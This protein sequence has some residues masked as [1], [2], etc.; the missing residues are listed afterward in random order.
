MVEFPAGLMDEGETPEMAAVRELKWVHR[1]FCALTKDCFLT[2][3]AHCFTREETGLTGK[4]VSTSGVVFMEPGLTNCSACILNVEVDG[5]RPENVNGDQDLDDAEFIEVV[6][7]PLAHL[8]EHLA[9]FTAQ[10]LAID[11]KVFTFARGIELA[12]T[13]RL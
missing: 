2:M 6:A 13:L 12:K 3:V 4:V 10:G 8:S 11:A 7:V 9:A 5:T 1:G